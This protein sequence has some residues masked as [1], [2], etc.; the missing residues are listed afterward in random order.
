MISEEWL[1]KHWIGD[2]RFINAAWLVISAQLCG[3]HYFRLL[4]R[5]HVVDLT[6]FFPHSKFCKKVIEILYWYVIYELATWSAIKESSTFTLLFM[7][8]KLIIYFCLIFCMLLEVLCPYPLKFSLMRYC[9]RIYDVN[10]AA[11]FNFSIL[12][13]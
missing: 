7:S 11:N 3:I 2:C 8:L 1:Y 4:T 10:L 13:R 12:N 9:I 6:R 5:K